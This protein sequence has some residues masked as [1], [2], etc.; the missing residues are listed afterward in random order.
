MSGGVTS[1]RL[2]LPGEPITFDLA[3]PADPQIG[4]RLPSWVYVP[5]NGP[6]RQTNSKELVFVKKTN[7]LRAQSLWRTD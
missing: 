7:D 6:K 2:Q 1:D 3:F 4:E 5:S